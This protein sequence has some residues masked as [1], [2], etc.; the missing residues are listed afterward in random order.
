MFR[1]NDLILLVVT[2]GTIGV[3]IAFPEKCKAFEPYPLYLMMIFL[4]FSFLKIE[5]VKI[6]QDVRKTASVLFVLCLVKLIVLPAGLYFLSLAIWPKYAVPVLLLSGVSTGVV[7]PFMGGLL[8]ASALLV[9]MMV[10]VTSFL[11]PFTLPVLVKIL[12]GKTAEISFWAMLEF[13]ALVIFIPA[14]V[15]LFL[16]KTAP[17]FT[18]KLEKLQFTISMAIFGLV[19]LGVFPRYSTFFRERPREIAG[20]ILVAFILS[21]IYHVAGFLAAWGLPKEDRLAGAA[22]FAYMNSVLIIVFSAQFFDPLSPMLAV[23]YM[24]P[25]FVMVVPARIVSDKVLR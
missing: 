3:A 20:A 23:V 25:F 14:A 19:N 1:K 21:A 6:F 4:F 11:V 22:S 7:A 8:G 17:S 18:K 13:L 2:F 15:N 5:F 9:L 24:F 12:V 16:R 10:V